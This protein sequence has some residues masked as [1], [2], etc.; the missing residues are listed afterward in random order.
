MKINVA[1][2]AVILTVSTSTGGNCQTT[3]VSVQSEPTT[4][5]GELISCSLV[6]N[7]LGKDRRY[8][9]GGDIAA[10]GNF[11]VYSAPKNPNGPVTF[12]LKLIIYDHVANDFIPA[13]IAQTHLVASDGTIWKNDDKLIIDGDAPGSRLHVLFLGDESTRFIE[14]IFKE[15]SFGIAFNREN[16][17]TDVNLDVDLQVESIDKD[18]GAQ[19][20][21]N[22]ALLSFNQCFLKIIDIS[23]TK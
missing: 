12:G 6:F 15:K 17:G 20:R 23:I 21:S 13:K 11:S 1:I 16:D 10:V 2:V 8:M 14:G 4:R 22:K 5:G 9:R 7:V 3:T 18:T 19:I